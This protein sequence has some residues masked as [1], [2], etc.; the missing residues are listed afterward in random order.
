MKNGSYVAY[1]KGKKGLYIPTEEN[2]KNI[3][4]AQQKRASRADYKNGME[5]KIFI[6]NGIK[7]KVINKNEDIPDG[8]SKGQIKKAKS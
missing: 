2:K 3:R 8:W 1:N 6:T 5:G 4:E 7:N